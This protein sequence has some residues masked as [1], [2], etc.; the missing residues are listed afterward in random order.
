MSKTTEIVH[1]GN[2]SAKHVKV[3][4]IQSGKFKNVS[5][6]QKSTSMPCVYIGLR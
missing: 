1:A 3:T 5:F 6:T 2:F 4:K